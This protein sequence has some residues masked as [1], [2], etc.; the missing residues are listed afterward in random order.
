MKQE[1]I[2]KINFISIVVYLLIYLFAF[3]DLDDGL[4]M[5]RIDWDYFPNTIDRYSFMLLF[6]GI[7]FTLTLLLGLGLIN[8]RKKSTYIYS[9][10]AGVVTIAL[11]SIVIYRM[12]SLISEEYER[13][14]VRTAF[15][16]LYYQLICWMSIAIMVTVVQI[17]LGVRG[18][19][20]FS[21][22]DLEPTVVDKSNNIHTVVIVCLVFSLVFNRAFGLIFTN[23]I[24]NS[25]YL[26]LAVGVPFVMLNAF[27]HRKWIQNGQYIKAIA[28]YLVYLIALSGVILHINDRFYG[29]EN[30]KRLS[31]IF[32]I[33]NVVG[34]IIAIV[35]L[36]YLIVCNRN[37]CNLV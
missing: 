3:G 22:D 17:C 27:I 25:V 16:D 37:K 33:S 35:W 26:A 23:I 1:A 24:M 5:C 8:K 14:E 9:I 11:N 20:T 6:V 2:K 34:V 21:N 18:L 36:I 32:N 13:T 10:V 12:I 31:H 28:G 30:I 4:Y 7:G 19:I 15:L 29:W